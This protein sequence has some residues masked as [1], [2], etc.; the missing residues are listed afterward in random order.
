M[1]CW[2]SVF[3]LFVC[4]RSVSQ[5][6]TCPL[7]INFGSTDLTHWYAYTGNN[8]DG[9]GPQAIMLKYDSLSPAPSGT[10]G[11]RT[12]LEYNLGSVLGIQVIT[13]STIDPFGGFT[14]IPIINGYNYGYSIKLGSTA[15]TR[16]TGP[17]NLGGGGYIRGVS[18]N[19]HV[20]PGPATEPYTMTYA[21]AMVLENGTHISSQQPLVSVTIKTPAGV[22][23]CA[24]PSYF[25][26]TFNNVSELNGR[27]ATLDSATAI[28]NGFHVSQTPSPNPNP[29]VSGGNIQYL[30]DVWT[31][32]WTEVT[33]DLS[34]YRGQLVTITFEADNCVPGGHFS[35]AY[36]AI[37]NSCAGLQISGNSLV[38]NNSFITY[39]VPTLSGASYD[40]VVPNSWTVISG[41]NDNILKVKSSS[42]GGVISVREKNS[43]A[44]LTDTIQ[45]NTLPSPVG[46]SVNGSNTV[47]EGDNNSLLS[48]VNYSGNITNWLSSSD[49]NTWTVI[50]DTTAIF[51]VDNLQQSTMYKVV[52]AKGG[53][54]PTDTSIP[55]AITVDEKSIGGQ[56]SPLNATLCAGQAAGEIL[57]LTNNN[58]SVQQWQYSVDGTNWTN[59][60]PAGNN[61]VTTI[62]GI[63]VSTQ[64]RTIVKNGVCPTD[65][66]A[67]AGIQF[68]P[69]SFPQ[70]SASPA[71]T[72]ICY[73]TAATLNAH[74]DV[75][76]SYAWTPGSSNYS[77]IGNEPFNDA[78]TITP[79][80][81]GY[82]VLHVLNNGCPNPFVDSLHVEVLDP[83]IVHAGRDTSVVAGEPLQFNA[84]SS[85][86]GPDNFSWVPATEL[87]DAFIPNPVA[88][89]TLNDNVI[90]YLVK[91]V[92]PFGCS[93]TATVNVKVFKTKPDIFVPNA[94][95]PGTSMNAI[96]RPIPVGIS[97]L[98]YFRIYNR[99][100]E[101]VYNTSTIGNGWDGTL[102][103]STQNA[104]GYVWMVKG[105]DYLGHVITKKG[106]MVLI[107]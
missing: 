96:F 102:N 45:I 29:T 12:I 36:L 24:S 25:L 46:G 77:N 9:N 100:G 17:S 101:L 8:G 88:V 54:C 4:L 107:R 20:P 21:Y 106:T 16:G 82:Y 14:T 41:A 73:G 75:G 99:L 91:A 52:V 90:S 27:G 68:D 1:K 86:P 38:C 67:V 15:I 26:P 18:Y 2:W 63:T 28:N 56:L 72:T 19:I 83:V 81:S 84:T 93:G 44:D 58:G 6:Q 57:T 64:Y 34:A 97:S 37:R 60:I 33:Y 7:N 50:P 5:S 65:T 69:V 31:K 78:N 71:D 103:G 89:Y 70:A 85:D 10:F 43:C 98:E 79:D 48:A 80:N 3:F 22:L 94:F 104:G 13:A 32:N 105:T 55:A 39:S 23:A 53:V 92:T 76:T 61:P 87:S 35:Y 66:S 42:A 11:T 62:K 51:T 95:T 49:G 74:I 47:C 40:W 59:L 30:Q